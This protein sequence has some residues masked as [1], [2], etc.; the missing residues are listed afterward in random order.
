MNSVQLQNKPCFLNDENGLGK[1]FQ[2]VAFLSAVCNGTMD[3][4]K[5]LILCQNESKLLHW[6]YHCSVILPNVKTIIAD[7]QQLPADTESKNTAPCI[8]LSSM[9]HAVAHLGELKRMK[10]RFVIVHDAQLELNFGSLAILQ[11]LIS[12]DSRKVIIC[13]VDMLVSCSRL[14]MVAP[15][16][17]FL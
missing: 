2:M 13:S 8:V 14:R 9:D 5:V 12:G 15:V 3:G 17:D 7:H 16:W 6:N 1:I 11:A 4:I 10:Y